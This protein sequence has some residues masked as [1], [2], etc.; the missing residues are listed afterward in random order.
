MIK[1]CMLSTYHSPYD[2]RVFYREAKSLKKAGYDVTVI[3]H[4]KSEVRKKT[5]GV[6]IIGISKFP[7]V[8]SF[9]SLIKTL[10]IEALKVDADVY[11]FHEPDSIIIAIYLKLFKRKKIIYDVH[12]YYKDSLVEMAIQRRIF[13][14]FILYFIE[15]LFIR[16]VDAVITVDDGIKEIYKSINKKVCVLPNF[17]SKDVFET[18]DKIKG[19]DNCDIVL[20]VGGLAE[21]RGIFNLI[22]A[23][24]KVSKTNP[25]IKLLLLG[26][27]SKSFENKCRKYVELNNLEQYVEFLGTVPHSYVVKY[28][29]VSNIGAVLL[30]PTPRFKKTPYVVKLF[31]YMICGKP[32]LASNLPAMGKIVKESGCGVLVNPTNIDEIADRITYLLNHPEEAKKMGEN[33]RMAVEEKYSWERMEERL[34]NIYKDI[35]S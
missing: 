26:K 31:E 16:Y 20:Y 6:E 22:K 30:L 25:R 33:G 23:V 32:V 12:E 15:P 10:L 8:K 28:I 27:S 7:D 9:I 14:S 19:Y 13:Y 24:H 1:V 11:H 35:L 34:L 4:I 29:N 17:P 21:V 5:D 18:K 3:G 2:G